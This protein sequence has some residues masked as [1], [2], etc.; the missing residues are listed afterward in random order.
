ML[1]NLY[2]DVATMARNDPGFRDRIDKLLT[3]LSTA[4]RKQEVIADILRACN[5][6]MGLLLPWFFPHF[7]GTNKGLSLAKRPFSFPLFSWV[8]YGFVVVRGSRQFGKSSS[9]SARQLVMTSGLAGPWTTT[10]IAPHQEHVK[11]Y[12]LKL[13][14]MQSAFRYYVR[15][16]G[17]KNNQ[18]LKSFP[19]PCLLQIYRVLTSAAHMRGKTSDEILYDEYQLFDMRLEAEIRQLQ[20]ISEAP[21]TFYCGTSTTIDSP[22]EN[23]F[24]QSSGGVWMMRTRSNIPGQEY[25]NCSDP[26]MVL[27]MVRPDGLTCPHTGLL[28]EDPTI[29]VLDHE[30][31]GMLE[32]KAIGIH[33]PQFIIP[34]FIRGREWSKIYDYLNFG[35]GVFLQEVAGI[36]VEEGGK[37]ITRRDLEEICTLPFSS[38]EA[39][40]KH[41]IKERPYRYV[42]SGCDWGGTDFAMASTIK[43]SYTVHAMLGVRGDGTRDIIHMHRYTGMDYDEIAQLIVQKHL[44]LGGNMIL[45]DYGAGYAYNTFLHRDSRIDVGRHFV[46]EYQAP[47]HPILMKPK[48]QQFPS[49]YLL[50]KTESIT[51]LFDEIKKK[52]I[53]CYAWEAARTCLE[54]LLHSQRVHHESR[55]GRGYFLHIRNNPSL[56]DDTMHAINFALVGAK[57]LMREPLFKDAALAQYIYGTV[58]GAHGVPGALQ[59]NMRNMVISG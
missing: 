8:P 27:K 4:S 47:Y 37:E 6:N 58:A 42:V 10:Y 54:D 7:G 52:N 35:E 31:P 50:N 23:R 2:H 12:S 34:N 59:T 43:K 41:V 46:L 38:R 11:T 39:I 5:Y 36:P 32:K 53:R 28:I 17:Y 19:G 16:T 33:V 15:R 22:L 25:V 3:Q 14:D 48:N 29:G 20:R 26:K 44:E 57:I 1:P 45:S 24:Q 13:M 56:P 49:H 40:Q 18:Y 9:L 51:M 30:R 55:H 21:M